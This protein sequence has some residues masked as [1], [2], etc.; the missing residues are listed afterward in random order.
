MIDIA[1]FTDRRWTEFVILKPLFLMG[2]SSVLD[3]SGDANIK[4][5]R[6]SDWKFV[7]SYGGGY[8]THSTRTKNFDLPA[9]TNGIV[10]TSQSQL[11]YSINDRLAVVGI[12]QFGI[13]WAKDDKGT[14]LGTFL[15]VNYRP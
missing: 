14:Q 8:F 4:V 1:A 13:A 6:V 5:R 10:F 11:G 2:E 9:I 15:G 3:P 7:F 12:L